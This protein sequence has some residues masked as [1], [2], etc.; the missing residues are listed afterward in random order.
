ML[1]LLSN[2]I[3]NLYFIFLIY[4]LLIFPFQ[5]GLRSVLDI[6]H[7]LITSRINLLDL[8]IE[9]QTKSN[10]FIRPSIHSSIHLFIHS[11]IYLSILSFFHLS[12]HSSIFCIN[13]KSSIHS[14]A[15]PSNH[16]IPPSI[17][18]FIHYTFQCL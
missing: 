5:P 11:S 12:L 16:L 14:S 18:P 2:L 9:V 1:A 6:S 13:H 4:F 3:F 7:L 8:L 17:C 10:S 15:H